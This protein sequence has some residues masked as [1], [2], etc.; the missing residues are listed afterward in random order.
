MSAGCTALLT[1]GRQSSSR[2]C[3]ASS[4]RTSWTGEVR[5]RHRIRHSIRISRLNSSPARSFLSTLPSPK[6]TSMLPRTCLMD[7]EPRSELASISNLSLPMKVQSLLLPPTNY[8]VPSYRD[9]NQ[10]NST[11]MCGILSVRE[12]TS[13]ASLRH[14]NMM[15]RSLILRRSWHML[16]ICS[17]DILNFVM[18]SRIW[19]KQRFLNSLMVVSSSGT[20]TKMKS[21]DLPSKKVSTSWPTLGLR[22]TNHTSS[23][24]LKTK[25]KQ[26]NLSMN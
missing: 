8:L 15:S 7:L 21:S 5:T 20:R 18:I 19:T 10:I 6:K 2:D 17:A 22:R 3:S 24:S 26:V 25:K 16:L 9:R 23:Q 13:P 1:A 4:E 14:T 11:R 12:L